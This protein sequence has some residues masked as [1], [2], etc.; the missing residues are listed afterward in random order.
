MGEYLNLGYADAE[1]HRSAHNAFTS[2]FREFRV[3]LE[4]VKPSTQFIAEFSKWITNWRIMHVQRI[5]KGLGTFL[6]DVLPKH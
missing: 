4:T 2:D 5:D 6:N 1:H 3:D